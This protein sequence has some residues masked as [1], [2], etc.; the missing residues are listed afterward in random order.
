MKKSSYLELRGEQIW[1]SQWTDNGQP[2]VLLHG[3][4]SSTESWDLYLLPAIEPSHHVYGYDRA[5]QGRTP[6]QPGS[7]HFNFQCDEAIAYLEDVVKKPAHLVGWSDGGIIALLVAIKRPDLVLSIIAIGANYHFN[8]GGGEIPAGE[9]SEAD[10]QEYAQLSPDAAH[11]LDEKV[12][13]ML[14]IWKVE[15]AIDLGDLAKIE[16]PTLVLAGDD[17]LFSFAHTTSLYEALP[18]GQLA[19][20]PGTSHFLMKEKPALV[21]EIIRQFLGDLAPPQTRAPVRRSNYE[22]G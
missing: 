15:P 9:I 22:A 18:Q 12:R 4:L 6:D 10:R 2:L 7:L 1:N 3:G 16:C 8:H 20:V 21:Q 17:E 5:G 14:A 11:T 13:R 19:I